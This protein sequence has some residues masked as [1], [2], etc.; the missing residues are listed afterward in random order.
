MKV[1]TKIGKVITIFLGY[2]YNIFRMTGSV[3]RTL[4]SPILIFH[5]RL[6]TPHDAF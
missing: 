2:P 3:Y 4:I 5:I 6:L 1:E